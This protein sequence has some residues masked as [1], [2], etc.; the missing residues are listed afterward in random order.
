MP[1]PPS[2]SERLLRDTLRRAEE[3]ERLMNP[4]PS[5]FGLSPPAPNSNVSPSV[6]QMFGPCRLPAAAHGGRRHRRNTSSSMQSDSSCDYFDGEVV[7][8]DSQEDEDDNG[9]PWRDDSAG[10]SASGHDHG[11]SYLPARAADN[12]LY[13]TPA[14]PSPARAQL[15]R[16][17][18]TS[19]SVP[20]RH[21][22]SQSVSHVAAHPPS[23]ASIDADHT[24]TPHEAV[25]RNKLEGVLKGVKVQDSRTRSVERQDPDSGFSSGSGNSMASSRNMSGEGDFFFGANGDSSLTSVNSYDG[26][27]KPVA[28][29]PSSPRTQ[30]RALH[31]AP[32]R[33]PRSAHRPLSS[34]RGSSAS[35]ASPLTPPPSPPFN[36]RQAAAQCRAMDGYISFATIEGLG[37]PEGSDEESEEEAKSRS[38]WF[39]WLH[40]SGKGAPPHD[41]AR[42]R[43]ESSSSMSR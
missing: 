4:P 5:L 41:R 7:D 25:L 40:I 24:L 33:S 23:R 38:R 37:V 6:A 43:S 36:A 22:H 29:G 2:R 8:E 17:G 18:K 16:A 30:S 42:G 32:N 14:S 35:S 9:W 1:R 31:M 13:G 27:F 28:I 20:R 26:R 12:A 39:Q 34:Q 3:Q 15:Q 21:S 19:P 11:H 10:S